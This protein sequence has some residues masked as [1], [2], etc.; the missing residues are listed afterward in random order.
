MLSAI[1]A[2]HVL[3]RVQKITDGAEKKMGSYRERV[4][5]AL[6]L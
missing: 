2:V 4:N 5:A 6:F 3:A 1:C